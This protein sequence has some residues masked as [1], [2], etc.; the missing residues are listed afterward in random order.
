VWAERRSA[1]S[2]RFA[3]ADNENTPA[4]RRI[5]DAR[6]AESEDEVRKG[7]TY[8][9]FNTA[10]EMIAH[11]KAALK[12]AGP[13]QENQAHSMKVDYLPRPSEPWEKLPCKLRW[14]FSNKS[15][16]LNLRH[17][18]LQAKK[19]D[20]ALDRWQARADRDSRF[21]FNIVSDTYVIRDVMAHPK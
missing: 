4:K 9:P 8:G 1:P 18:S 2:R 14:H 15:N 17:P 12:E 11:L 6:Q 13:G 16:C 3:A 19:Y 21:Y 7:R 20:A 10:D 5:I